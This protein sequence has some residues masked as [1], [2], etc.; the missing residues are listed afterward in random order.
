MR[1]WIPILTVISIVCTGVF[2][3]A[4]GPE[5]NFVDNKLSV[6]VETIPLS[7]LLQLVDLATGM[8]SKV[9]AE[10]ANRNVS[11]KF[12][13][14]SLPDA[15]RKLFQGQPFDY[16]VIEGQSIVVTSAAQ[17]LTAAGDAP[18]AYNSAPSI[19]TFE[20]PFFQE[21][22]P[23]LQQQFQPQQ[24]QPAMVQTPFGP[25]PNPRAQQA[26]PSLANLAQQQNS[27]FPPQPGQTGQQPG[28][29]PLPGMQNG[30]PSPFGTPTPFG[31]S[32]PVTNPNNGLF[33]SPSVLVPGSQQR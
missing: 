25:I 2:A 14:L 33:G 10:L 28:F 32:P 8:K 24:G 19:Q 6:N 20:Q 12:S 9:P 3:S 30:N 27:L 17:T 18:P 7:R 4:K 15:V 21:A 13:G 31:V 16:V 11:V 29:A 26:N 5:V 1:R 23:A 22:P